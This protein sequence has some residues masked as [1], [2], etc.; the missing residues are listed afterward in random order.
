MKK[1]LLIIFSIAIILSYSLG[2]NVFGNDDS[3]TTCG[4]DDLI[5]WYSVVIEE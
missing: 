5:R 1:G 4:E 3:V 2:L